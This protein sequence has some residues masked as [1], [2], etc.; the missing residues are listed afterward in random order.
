MEYT[1]IKL[2]DGTTIESNEQGLKKQFTEK[3]VR[4]QQVTAVDGTKYYL[5]PTSIVWF[6]VSEIELIDKELVDAQLNC[7][8]EHN[9]L[10]DQLKLNEELVQQK[11]EREIAERIAF[12]DMQYVVAAVA[13][14]I[15]NRDF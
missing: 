9:E 5:S 12:R 10:N 14:R 6:K 1:L 7:L 3:A 13:K 4:F 15:D 8:E 2:A 11:K